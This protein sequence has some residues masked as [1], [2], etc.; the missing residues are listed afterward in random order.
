MWIGFAWLPGMSRLSTEILA[1]GIFIENEAPPAP[2]WSEKGSV[3][4]SL[5]TLDMAISK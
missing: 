1:G 3:K 5:L 2:A 4:I